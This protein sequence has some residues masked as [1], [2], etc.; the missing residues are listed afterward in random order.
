MSDVTKL[1]KNGL[2][3]LYARPYR[4]P[5]EFPE[6]TEKRN[7]NAEKKRREKKE[8]VKKKTEKRFGQ[9]KRN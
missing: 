8:K 9:N 1:D 2:A 4:A 7:S 3:A 5:D 6:D